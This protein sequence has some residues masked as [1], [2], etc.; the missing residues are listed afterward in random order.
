MTVKKMYHREA[1]LILQYLFVLF[2]T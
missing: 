2:L 1:V